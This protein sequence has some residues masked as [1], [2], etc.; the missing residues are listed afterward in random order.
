MAA[1]EY[2]AREMVKQ[3]EMFEGTRNGK[4]ADEYL[5]MLR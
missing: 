3:G 2:L 4:Y 1:S 5:A